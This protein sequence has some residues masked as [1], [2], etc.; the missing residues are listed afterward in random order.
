MATPTQ[1]DWF[2][3]NAPQ[4]AARGE[5][6]G[7]GGGDWFSENAP[8]YS[9]M[10]QHGTFGPPDVTRLSPQ[11]PASASGGAQA[12][13]TIRATRTSDLPWYNRPSAWLGNAS[14]ALNED[15]ENANMAALRN[16]A[17][18]GSRI[19]TLGLQTAGAISR[20]AGDVLGLGSSVATPKG[21]AI[22]AA[23]MIPYVGRVVQTGAGAYYGGKGMLGVLREKQPGETNF[24]FMM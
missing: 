7:A 22:T 21:A 9:A 8:G 2:S 6:A 13:G 14:Q 15:A 19:G 12:T 5:G 16:T 20:T 4:T 10:P 24:Q 1:Q 11:S 17:R 18:G 23:S 3:A